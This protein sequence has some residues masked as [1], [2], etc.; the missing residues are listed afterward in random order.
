MSEEIRRVAKTA[1][2]YDDYDKEAAS[3]TN[4]P[5]SPELSL[6]LV[7]AVGADGARV[8]IDCADGVIIAVHH[9]GTKRPPRA[10]D[11]DL[12]GKVLLPAL[13]EPH[14]HVD[15]A[16]TADLY[17]NPATDFDGAIAASGRSFT[18]AT[19]QDIAGRAR[20]ALLAFVAKGCLSVRTHVV[21]GTFFGMKAVEAVTSVVAELGDLVDVQVV[22]HITPPVSGTAGRDNRALLRD[23]L[24]MGATQVG[25]NPYWSEDPVQETNACLEEAARAGVGVDLHTDETMDPSCLTVLALADAV[26]RTGFPHAVVASHCVSLGLQAPGTQRRVAEA[27][28]EAGVSVVSLPQTN[29]YLMGR[30]REEA[31][32]RGMT[33]LAALKR[34]GVQVAA[35]GDNMQDPFN[36]LGRA[37]PLEAASLFVCAGQLGLGDAFDAVTSSARSV[38]G[39]P[40][41]ALE[42]GSPADL[43]ALPGGG[44]RE[45]MA[46]AST[47][48][49]VVRRGQVVSDGVAVSRYTK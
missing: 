47:S 8:D 4:V 20:R 16:Y 3:V 28:A 29:L 23:A 26:K 33:A 44:L 34:A 6:S 42:V 5:S 21:V 14:T 25:G 18:E 41:V 43:V 10:A 22:A 39:W 12:S 15:K 13:V 24:A 40:R 11:I 49:V 19:V 38:C 2:T 48:R 9:G 17:P 45:A 7:G 31:K 30:D 36:P 27:M 37:D 46:E 1:R 32:P 35:G